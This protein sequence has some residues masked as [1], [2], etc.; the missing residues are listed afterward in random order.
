[1]NYKMKNID[2]F[3]SLPIPS[4]KRINLGEDIFEI[5]SNSSL[6]VTSNNCKV[7]RLSDILAEEIEQSTLSKKVIDY[8][9]IDYNSK[10][11]LGRKFLSF[12]NSSEESYVVV[13]NENSDNSVLDITYEAVNDIR[14][15]FLI[16][17]EKNARLTVNID[18][19]KVDDP[20]AVDDNKEDE[21]K[22]KT[23]NLFK[24]IGESRSNVT[25]NRVQRL[26]KDSYNFDQSILY[27]EDDSLIKFN[28]IQIGSAKKA[29]SIDGILKGDRSEIVLSSA[30]FGDLNSESDISYSMIHEG[31]KS[32]S[33]ILS[34]G[35][36]QV[37][38]KKV[39][40]GNLEFEKGSSGST[41][42]EK[43]YVLLL[44][45]NI[46]SDSIPALMCSEDDVI[47]EHAASVGQIDDSKLFYIMS[48]G[49]DEAEA[50]K[51][52]VKASFAEIIEHIGEDVR[53]D[54]MSEIEGRIS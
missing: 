7:Y 9:N 20:K 54:I 8:I 30:Y 45:E 19:K 36:L 16:V 1:M 32:K 44:D 42:S 11:N 40:R 17:A 24:V 43:E 5:K 3:N 31:K 48:R 52:I 4:W 6:S 41:G 23:F 18:Y 34:K 10:K 39:F 53:D 38:S 37:G 26:S 25:I 2:E 47:G 33:E 51:L 22:V 13:S 21:I 15:H 46:K 28:D 29:I 49:L 12:M 14:T 27:A 35:A 50:K